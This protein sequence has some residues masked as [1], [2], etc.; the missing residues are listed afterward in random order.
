MAEPNVRTSSQAKPPPC[1]YS[2]LGLLTL[3]GVLRNELVPDT[4]DVGEMIRQAVVFVHERAGISQAKVREVMRRK[5]A[6]IDLDGSDPDENAEL[7]RHP[8]HERSP[9]E[10]LTAEYRPG[11][12]LEDL[13]GV[14]PRL[15]QL[16]ANGDKERLWRRLWEGWAIFRE[17]I[18]PELPQT[19]R[20]QTDKPKVPP[21]PVGLPAGYTGQE[22]LT[23]SD[24]AG[25]AGVNKDVL[26]KRLERFRR[27]SDC[28]Y[29]TITNKG[30]R[31]AQYVYHVDLVWHI[32]CDLK[33]STK[34]R[35]KKRA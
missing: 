35:S 9:A 6:R 20:E 29:E 21:A 22:L 1:P 7:C 31:K 18:G 28:G 10:R 34:R 13:S 2:L 4:E 8:L 27:E 5:A 25:I 24:L 32:V 3:L 15:R 33:T 23:C 11:G 26:A 16:D 17:A 14:L 12:P 30:R 19:G